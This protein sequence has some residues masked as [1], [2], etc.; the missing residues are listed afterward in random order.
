MDRCP[1]ATDELSIEYHDRE[2]GVPLHD[3][4][5][6]FEF[7]ILEGAQAGLSWTTIL[8]KRENYRRVFDHF[9]PQLVA[10]YTDKK[11]EQLLADPGIIR[12]PLK[13]AAAVGNAQAYLAVRY[14]VGDCPP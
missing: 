3:D 14:D 10:E 1:W 8:K 4:G 6:L 5:M 7:L 12:N 13:V 2:W 9:D 11:I